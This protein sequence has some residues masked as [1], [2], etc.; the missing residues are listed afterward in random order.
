MQPKIGVTPGH[1]SRYNFTFQKAWIECQ[2]F[3]LDCKFKFAV[4]A[5]SYSK[6]KSEL[7][8]TRGPSMNHHHHRVVRA[9][10]SNLVDA[11]LGLN[12]VTSVLTGLGVEIEQRRRTASEVIWIVC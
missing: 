12:D 7:S 3:P 1:K 2:T 10:L 4:A 9:T 11:K 8:T 6:G 5:A